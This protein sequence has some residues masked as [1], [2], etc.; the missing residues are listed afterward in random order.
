MKIYFVSSEAYP[1]SKT[2]GLADMAYF[3]PKSLNAMHIDTKV[4]T[5]YYK[6]IQKYA[7]QMEYIGTKTVHVSNH[8]WVFKYYLMIYETTTYYFI[9]NMHL[10]ERDNLYGYEDD[11]DRFTAF[12]YA[13]LELFD[14]INDY[15]QILHL[16]DWQ[17]G[18]IPYLLDQK[19]RHRNLDYNKIH[20]LLT[21][22]NLQ[23]QGSFDQSFYHYFSDELDYTYMHFNAINF[24]KA[25]IERA[26][27]ITTVSPTYRN[28]IL[29]QD[30]GFT[31]DGIL[32][33]RQHDLYG[34][35]NGIDEEIFNPET[36]PLL[37]THY[38]IKN[39]IAQKKILKK[40]II[41]QYQLKNEYHAPLIA[42]IG[43]L[44]NQKGV[45]IILQAIEDCINFSDAIFI[46]LGSGNENYE[47]HIRYLTSKYPNR[48][49][50]YIGFN[51]QVA[52]QIYAGSDIFLMP[53]KF[54][55]CGLGQMIAMRYGSLPIVTE[56]GGLKDTVIPYNKYT[57]S[58]TGFSFAHYSLYEFKEQIYQA[59]DLYINHKLV[60]NRLVRQ[61]MKQD[62][63][64]KQ[65]ARS[66]DLLYRMI[67]EA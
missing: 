32:N 52:H 11:I 1:F 36:D 63:G 48:I 4:I 60:F 59:I 61:A 55:P 47:H 38:Q 57:L 45:D 44:A 27:K 66:Y 13:V 7:E 17:T 54:E 65:V 28:E 19:Y 25:G 39:A 40:Q 29:T 23:Y 43:R 10:F 30:Y 49:A 20:T 41:E 37:S 16:N 67:M 24:L 22:H 2:G 12:D 8:E 64:L 35:L 53:S 33:Q 56:T 14:L 46:I 51:E 6:Q 18:M 3:L 15:P 31:L 26:T 50:N 9:Q 21:I 58:G 5:P 42:Y 62:Y 34:I